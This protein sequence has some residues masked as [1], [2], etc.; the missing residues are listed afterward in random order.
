[1]DSVELFL[2]GTAALLLL[3]VFASK[4]SG[5]LGIPTLVV[6]LAVGIFAGSEGPLGIQFDNAYLAQTLGVVALAYILF[7]GGLDTKIKDIR[8]VMKGGASLASLGVFITCVILG[9]FNHYVLGFSL[10]EG[11]LI[12]AIVSST[13]AGAVFTVLRSKSIH[14]KGNLKPMLELESG[15]ND[16]MAVFLTTSILTMMTAPEEASVYQFVTSLVVQIIV[17][18]VIGYG[19]GRLGTFVINKLK[20]EFE[21]LYTVMTLALVLLVYS[22]TQALKGNGFLAVYV[23]GVVLGNSTFIFKKS[24]MLM[25][26]GVSWL[27]QSL[28]FLTL[29]LLLYPSKVLEVTGTGFFLAVFLMFVARP[30]SVFIGLAFDKKTSFKEKLLISWVG[31][32][33]SVPI[34]MATFPLVA[35]IH[36]ADLIFNLVFFIALTSLIFQGSSIPFVSRL[37]GVEAEVAEETTSTNEQVS[38]A[39]PR[40]NMVS[41]LVPPGSAIVGKAVVDLKLPEDL[42]I[43]LIE[44]EGKT[45]IPRGATEIYE[46]DKLYVLSEEPG[47]KLMKNKIAGVEP[48]V[49]AT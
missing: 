6:F 49:A 33:G 4:A 37:L 5:K 2:F 25:H 21:G 16:P 7:S 11:M 24:I 14:L 31:L 41:V 46:N 18:G 47:L 9:L 3:C 48:E 23:A 27:M 12:G 28:L 40:D 26:D 45:V 17:G 35:G 19:A 15:S 10:L 30:I 34:V 36:N 42:L 39:N 1:M 13:D 8:P 32:R 22:L 20:L 44:R 29:G 43:V 38:D